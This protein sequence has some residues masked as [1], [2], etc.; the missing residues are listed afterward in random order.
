M[1]IPAN[2]PY[3]YAFLAGRPVHERD[4]FS[5]RHP[6]MERGHRAKIFAPF[7]ALDGFGWAVRTKDVVYVPRAELS[8]DERRMLDARFRLLAARASSAARGYDGLPEV[9]AEYY[10]PCDDPY[11]DAYGRAGTY[12]TLK[13]VCRHVDE[14]SGAILI[15]G[16][17]IRFEDIRRLDGAVF[18][19]DEA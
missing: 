18:E 6:K 13:G 7:A 19:E 5:R 1:D 8:E 3:T 9:T 15:G 14:I 12:R 16:T 4:D 17:R 10:V 2:F 11:H